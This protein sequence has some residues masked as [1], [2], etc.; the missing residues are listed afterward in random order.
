[1]DHEMG[2]AGHNGKPRARK[3]AQKDWSSMTMEQIVIELVNQ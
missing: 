3:Q 2:Y 1:M